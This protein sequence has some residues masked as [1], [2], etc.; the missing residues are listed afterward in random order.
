MEGFWIEGGAEGMW[1]IHLADAE[2]E[3]DTAA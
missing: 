1:R 3:A 2:T